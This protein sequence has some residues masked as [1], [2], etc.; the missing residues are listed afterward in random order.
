MRTTATKIR[1]ITIE[2]KTFY[3]V[4]WPK[5]PKGRNRQAFRQKTEA[6]T[7]LKQKLAEQRNY[8]IAGSGL[9]QH[10]G[11]QIMNGRSSVMSIRQC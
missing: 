8:G 3:E 4:Q 11:M 6:E 5:F 2:G 1:E 7:F 9:N 10:C